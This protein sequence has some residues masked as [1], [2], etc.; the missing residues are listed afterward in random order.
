MG[1]WLRKW[2]GAGTFR[3][4]WLPL[5]QAKLGPAYQKVSAV[6]I[7]ATIARMYQARQSG[8][9]KEMF[10]YLPGGYARIFREYADQLAT[11]GVEVRCSAP[12]E[13]VIQQED[14]GV[15]VDLANGDSHDFDYALLT[16]PSSLIARLCS[17]LTEEER[18]AHQQIEYLGILC[19]SVVLKK[20]LSP[21]YVTNITD[22][23]V[24]FTAVIEMTALVDPS[25]LAGHHLVVFA[26][27]RRCRRSRLAMDRRRPQR[28]VSCRL[29]KDGS[30]L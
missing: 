24:P 3:K 2:S 11:A 1:D 22:S 28:R 6:F 30:S 26:S 13:R 5:L 14:G 15:Q 16:T 8:L 29:G 20:P 12:I 10:G 4:L 18:N 23:W 21:Y 19:A 17:Q 27:L 7:W 25:E 9:K